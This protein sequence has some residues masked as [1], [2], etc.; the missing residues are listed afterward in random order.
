M[1]SKLDDDTACVIMEPVIFDMPQ[2][3][4]LRDVR[5]LCT[6][7]G[8]LLVFDEMWTGFRLALGGAQEYFDTP[9]DLATFSKAISN[10]MPI[11][12]LT[13]RRDVMRRCDEDVF[14]STTYGGEALS[15]AAT[16]AT[17]TKLRDR[18]VP[19]VLAA[20]GT[21][22][23]TA[24]NEIAE[25]LGLDFTRCIGCPYH[26]MITFDAT[27][28]DPLLCKSLVQQELIRRGVLWSGFHNVC[29]AL[30]NE[31][32]DAV[33]AAYEDVLPLLGRAVNG[34]R[35]SELLRGR[36]VEPVFRDGSGKASITEKTSRDGTASDGKASPLHSVHTSN[37]PDILQQL[38]GSLLVTT[39]QAGTLVVLRPDPDSRTINTHFRAFRKPMGLAVRP[40]RIAVGTAQGIWELHNV[41]AVAAKLEPADKYDACFLPRWGHVTGDIAI[42]EMAYAGK[43]L[44]FVNTRFSCLCVSDGE[45]SFVPRWRP[46]FVS[47]IAPED[48]CHLNG[49]GL[50]DGRP[51]YVTALGETDI[52]AGWRE[53]K[54]TGGI[55]VDVV[56]QEVVAGG[57]SMPHSPRWHSGRL[58]VLELGRG[59]LGYVDLKSGRYESIIELP[60][61]TRGLDFAGNLAFVGLSQVRESAVFSGIE[62]T[63]RLRPEDRTCGVWVIDISSGRIVA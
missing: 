12:V 3:S 16:Q 9:A 37:F 8:A 35:V 48:R 38:R 51:R 19:R 61:F 29:Y 24:Y 53:N 34:A 13:G 10:G 47:H 22:L 18:D 1:A 55:L 39:Y 62:I 32:V 63:E 40:N 15:L 49:L 44:W 45:H 7:T 21:K 36:P 58:W 46:S 25:K 33:I 42:H 4:F 6:E 14:F 26:S 11:S 30:G 59:G 28:A 5:R 17:L 56:T 54:K 20:Q 52:A 50:V 23:Q 60:G 41:P 2:D 27:A 43:E 31:E 57:L